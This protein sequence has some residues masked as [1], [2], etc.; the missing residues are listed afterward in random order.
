MKSPAYS[1]YPDAFEQG[2]A[3]MT[4][5]EVGAYQRLLNHQWASGAV[6]GDDLKRLAAILRCTPAMAKAI[7][8]VVGRKF[9]RD[10]EGAWRNARMEQEREKQQRR[11]EALAKN[12]ARGGRPKSDNQTESNRL[13]ESCVP[14]PNSDNQTE[15]LPSPSPSLVQKNPPVA[16]R[17]E[18]ASLDPDTRTV[19]S[20]V[21]VN[22]TAEDRHSA[23]AFQ[24][25]MQQALEAFGCTVGRE[26]RIPD[27]GDGRAGAVDLVVHAPV[28]LALELDRT[29]PRQKSLDKLRVLARE[30]YA[31]VVVCRVGERFSWRQQGEIAIYAASPPSARGAPLP[32]PWHQQE[33]MAEMRRLMADGLSYADAQRKAFG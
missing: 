25:A 33:R 19:L 4:L 31:G 11:S 13:S 5:P 14:T 10:T 17:R 6:P 32:D 21:L 23:K 8:A 29:T 18:A 30:G 15:S 2:T 20:T 22:L 12:G 27:R 7:W 16:S 24:D 28:K 26:H 9:V 1:Y 3:M